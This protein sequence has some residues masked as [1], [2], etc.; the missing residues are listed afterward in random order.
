IADFARFLAIPNLASDRPN[1]IR[2]AQAI[3]E[4]MK[5]RRIETRLLELDGAPPVVL[6]EIK[7]PG[8]RSTITFYAH[9]DGQPVDPA[10]WQTGPW[11]PVLRRGSLSTGEAP[12]DPM[13][14]PAD[15]DPEWRLYARS[16]SDDKAPIICF[17][18][19]LDALTAAH[20]PI[21]VNLRFFFEGE[22]EAGSPHLQAFLNKY[23]NLLH[24]DAWILCD[25]P[26]HQSHRMQ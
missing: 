17:M 23:A 22:E 20:T 8:A 21:S 19:A 10:Q 9:Y 11:T 14:P 15:L 4:M 6:G 25:G 18:A 12:I 7:T 13:S 5:A 3:V 2:N 16:A 24:T 26:V 1:I